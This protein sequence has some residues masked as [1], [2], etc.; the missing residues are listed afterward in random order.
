M[1][2]TRFCPA[3]A[4]KE[5]GKTDVL[6]YSVYNDRDC[7]IEGPV[8]LKKLL[9]RNIVPAAAECVRRD[10]YEK[11]SMFPLNMPMIGDWFLWCEFASH[12]KV[13]YLSE[14]MVWPPST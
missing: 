2:V 5:R 8:F 10:R 12:Y 7:I 14:P 11:V 3:V 1:F 6:R 4:V 9:F 13:S